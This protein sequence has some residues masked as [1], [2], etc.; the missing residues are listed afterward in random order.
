MY[1]EIQAKALVEK[2]YP[3]IKVV[4]SFRYNNIFL[5]RI[6]HPDPEEANYDPFLSVNPN[7]GEIKEFSVITDGDP[8]A[9]DKAFKIDSILLKR[10]KKFSNKYVDEEVII[11]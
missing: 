2:K 7:T 11:V 5:V 4:D 10:T 1:N 3:E 8:V 6:E 9:I